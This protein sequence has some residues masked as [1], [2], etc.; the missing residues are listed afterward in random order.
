MITH[1]TPTDGNVFADLG[2]SPEEAVN[3]KIRSRMMFEIDQHIRRLGIDMEEA[4]RVY[5][6]S[7][8]RIDSLL[9]GQIDLFTIDELV[10][11]L[12]HA[13]L[14]VAISIAPKKAA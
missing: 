9:K 12:S 6:V 1:T 3:L 7:P 13:G 14:D 2:A 8:H 4:A 11:M 10:N 5:G